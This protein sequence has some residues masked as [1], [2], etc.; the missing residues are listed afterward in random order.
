MAVANLAETT[1]GEMMS[2]VRASQM[3]V[4][5]NERDFRNAMGKFATGV[6]VISSQHENQVHAMT[7]NAFMSGSLDPA[8]VIVSVANRAASHEKITLGERF[9]IS[10]LTAEQ[11]QVSNHFAGKRS[12]NFEPEFEYLNGFPVIE[13][14][15]VQLVTELKFAYPCGDHTLFVGLV[16]GL[17]QHDQAEPLLFH[18][19]HYAA[20]TS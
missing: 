9:G 11:L 2:I 18:C 15:C 12:E 3:D 6:V 13:N 19:G 4:D 17:R 16:T 8:M 20:L 5:F 14:A 10:I 7:A 1:L